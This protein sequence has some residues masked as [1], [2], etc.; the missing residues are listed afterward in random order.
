MKAIIQD[1]YGL[2]N[3][4]L[5]L[6]EIDL[7]AIGDDDV[8]VRVRA[9]SVHADIWHVV[10]GRPY[11]LRL[12]GGGFS[13]PK[14]PVPGTDMAGTVEA[15]GRNVTRFRPGDEVFGETVKANQWTNGGAFAEY[16]S[17][18][19]DALEHKPRN[20]S[21]E[22]AAG[23]PTSGLI[24]L[25]NLRGAR[26]I[27]PGQR[28]LINGAAG[29]VGSLAVQIAKAAGAVV[30]GVDS[31]AKLDLVRSLGADRVIDYTKEDFTRSGERYDLIIDV[32]ST[33]SLAD[34]RRA[35]APTGVYILIGHDHYGK[36]G[37]RVLGSLPRFFLLAAIS[38]FVPQLG[39]MFFEPLDRRKAM[40]VLKEL[41]E[42]GRL[43][44]VV[45]R[46]FP[47]SE[48][49]AAIGYLQEGT[50]RGKIV[51]VP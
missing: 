9:A 23:V 16:V 35:L 43:T 8:L 28:V 37:R 19:H 49:P 50:A 26:R 21:F 42:A 44:P 13:R 14:N 47:L 4:V 30:T 20:I 46:T 12:M 15:V 51:V 10:T 32:A 5:R 36:A 11:V 39:K 27:R 45:D 31:A 22:Q 24:V 17:V 18:R 41:L 34:S 1:S 40:P 2:P 48:V 38:P 33:L 6:R 3:D 29:G 25:N 7:P